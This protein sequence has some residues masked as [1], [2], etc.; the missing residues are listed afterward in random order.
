MITILMW[1]FT[2]LL[3]VFSLFDFKSKAV[4]SVLLTGTIF[5][6]A[7]L[8]FANFKWAVIL[9]I[10]GWML[11]EFS[12]GNNVS[13]GVADIKIMIMLGF[14]IATVNSMFIFLLSFAIGQVFYIFTMKK[15]FEFDEVPFIPLFLIL[16]IAGLIAGGVW[17]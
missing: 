5:F 13:F 14:F 1:I 2:A 7:F 8:N 16:W 11:W 10:L 4:P 17:A 6:L 12:E 15:I 3:L 9:G